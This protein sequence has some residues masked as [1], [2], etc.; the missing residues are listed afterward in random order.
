MSFRKALSLNPGQYG[1]VSI[2]ANGILNLKT[3]TYQFKTLILQPDVKINLDALSGPLIVKV[4]DNMSFGDRFSMTLVPGSMPTQV[5][6]YSQQTTGLRL[7]TDSRFIGLL[8]APLADIDVNSRPNQV[9]E[10]TFYGTVQGKTIRLEPDVL[11]ES[12]S[13]P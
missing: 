6:F 9:G 3:G 4:R 1:D 10:A 5:R 13:I 12:L 7:G 8:Q 11:V 2:Q